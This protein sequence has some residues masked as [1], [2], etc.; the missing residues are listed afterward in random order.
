M[1]CGNAQRPKLL[2]SL[3]I[4][5]SKYGV[6]AFYSFQDIAISTSPKIIIIIQKISRGVPLVTSGTTNNCNSQ[7]NAKHATGHGRHFESFTL[8]CYPV[9]TMSNNF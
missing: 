6:S 5:T 9:K 8:L 7:N 4:K 3:L 2:C 1:T